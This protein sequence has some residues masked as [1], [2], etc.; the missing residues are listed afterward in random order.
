MNDSS[1]VSLD[2]A[3]RKE[4]QKNEDEL[5]A[6]ALH[7]KEELEKE[8][9][10]RSFAV[11]SVQD[12]DRVSID[13]DDSSN[14]APIL[15][16]IE[17]DKKEEDTTIVFKS[18][19][20]IEFEI[21]RDEKNA[22]EVYAKV[23]EKATFSDKFSVTLEIFLTAYI[24]ALSYIDKDNPRLPE[25][26]I[27]SGEDKEMVQ[28]FSYLAKHFEKAGLLGKCHLPPHPSKDNQQIYDWYNDSDINSSEII[29]DKLVKLFGAN[30]KDD[31]K[32]DSKDLV[33]KITGIYLGI[34]KDK[35]TEDSLNSYYKK[36]N[37][38]EDAKELSDEEND[39]LDKSLNQGIY[40]ALH[41]KKLSKLNDK[42]E[43]L[44]QS[45]EEV[46]SKLN[47]LYDLELEEDK[48]PALKASA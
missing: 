8:K 48:G 3:K 36:L 41:Q 5:I 29:N 13:T 17:N 15:N 9:R 38:K 27:E 6:Y 26:R 23:S 40:G 46:E 42:F 45:Y 25:I 31:G 43:T 35:L 34:P 39:F 14:E 20:G 30:K 28:I 21:I 16:S 10:N 12:D 47:E 2:A 22:L 44:K 33:N 1:N 32:I 11:A 37:Y 7:Q 18:L 4:T 19:N 24:D